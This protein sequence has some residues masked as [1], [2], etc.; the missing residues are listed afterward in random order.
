MPDQVWWD[1][2][3]RR[4][5]YRSPLA[6]LVIDLVGTALKGCHRPN[7]AVRCGGMAWA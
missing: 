1:R 6:E 4:E 5:F 3:W 7:T 2:I